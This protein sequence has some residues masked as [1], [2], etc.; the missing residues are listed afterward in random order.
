DLDRLVAHDG[1]RLVGVVLDDVGGEVHLAERRLAGL[2]HLAHDAVGEPLPP[3]PMQL[4]RPPEERR[5][6]GDRRR[7]RPFPV[8]GV[9]GGERPLDLLAAEGVVLGERLAGG[10]IDDGVGAHRA[11]LSQMPQDAGMRVYFVDRNSWMPSTLPS[12]PMPDC[13]TPPKGAAALETTP[14]LR[15]IMPVSR[16]SIMRLPRCR[17][18]VKT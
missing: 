8:R 6:L 4:R 13:F 18:S 11:F 15:P 16:A 2:A 9:G 7:P 17:F 3:F 12:R 10:R 1:L 14:A 5:P